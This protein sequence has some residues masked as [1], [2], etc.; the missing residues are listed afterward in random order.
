MNNI[1]MVIK[2]TSSHLAAIATDNLKLKPFNTSTHEPAQLMIRI[3]SQV[4]IVP[5]IK[6]H[7]SLHCPA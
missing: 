5:F 7:F 6:G 4:M 1:S 2:E 3:N